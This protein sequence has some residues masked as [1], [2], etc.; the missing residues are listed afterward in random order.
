D[1]A[2]GGDLSQ[3]RGLGA[4]EIL[5][6]VVPIAGALA[7]AHDAG[8]VHRDVKTSNVLFK[9][10]GTPQLADFGLALTQ[11]VAP[12]SAAGRGS[13]FSRS[14][15]QASGAPASV[16]DD[17]YGFGAMLCELFTGYPPSYPD[18]NSEK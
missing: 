5:R 17:M 2:S 1:Y 14:R 12:S 18:A 11:D 6:A 8:I 10:D 16:A 9:A 13:P 15:R 7:Y 4:A 3:L